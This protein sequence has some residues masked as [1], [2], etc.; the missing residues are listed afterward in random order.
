[1]LGDEDA[2]AKSMVEQ[3]LTAHNCKYFLKKS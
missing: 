2:D 3:N 1:M